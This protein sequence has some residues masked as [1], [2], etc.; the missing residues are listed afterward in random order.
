M[1]WNLLQNS[2]TVSP[3]TLVSHK[4]VLGVPHAQ[5]GLQSKKIKEKQYSVVTDQGSWTL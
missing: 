5:K 4:N 3:R 1:S 2:E